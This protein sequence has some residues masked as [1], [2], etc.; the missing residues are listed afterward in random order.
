MPLTPN[1]IRANAT[2]V[3]SMAEAEACIVA[4]GYDF[5]G[6]TPDEELK[7]AEGAVVSVR[8]GRARYVHPAKD[9][10]VT[11]GLRV[12]LFYIPDRDNPTTP[13]IVARLKTSDLEGIRAQLSGRPAARAPKGGNVSRE[14]PSAL[15]FVTTRGRWW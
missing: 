4:A 6:L 13:R 5:D 14:K 10:R 8:K 3:A 15:V 1:L 12:V 2:A 11:L 9:V 7:D